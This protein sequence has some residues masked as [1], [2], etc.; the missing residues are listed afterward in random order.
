MSKL[1]WSRREMLAQS[2]ATSAVVGSM[3]LTAGRADAAPAA[4]K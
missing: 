2:L 1:V 3:A 4:A